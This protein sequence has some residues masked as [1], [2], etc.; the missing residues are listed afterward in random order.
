M[1]VKM[2]AYRFIQSWKHLFNDLLQWIFSSKHDTL[3]FILSEGK[4]KESLFSNC[5]KSVVKWR[6]VTRFASWTL[7]IREVDH[8]PYHIN[9]ALVA[10]YVSVWAHGSERDTDM[11]SWLCQGPYFSRATQVC[12]NSSPLTRYHQ[13]FE[14]QGVPES[15]ERKQ[16]V[17]KDSTP[18]EESV[19]SPGFTHTDATLVPTIPTGFSDGLTSI[20]ILTL[21]DNPFNATTG[22]CY[23]KGQ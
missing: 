13:S 8:F 1:D 10:Y 7:L 21:N 15:A 3:D 2:K 17:F 22:L 23:L 19:T 20:Q 18:A 16:N 11:E 14:Q 9:H 5:F 12:W 6:V 4:I